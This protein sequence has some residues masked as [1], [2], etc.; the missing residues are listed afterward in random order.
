MAKKRNKTYKIEIPKKIVVK[1]DDSTIYAFLATILSIVGFIIAIL[2]KRNDKYV[3]YYA[4][5]SLVIFIIGAVGGLI[6]SVLNWI[7]IIGP[8]INFGIFV[9]V[10]LAWVLSWIYALTGKEKVIPIITEWALNFKF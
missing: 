1:K 7:P 4:K 2:A 6:G 9:V 10:F 5:H 3:M 8:I